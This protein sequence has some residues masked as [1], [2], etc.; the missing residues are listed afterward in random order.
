M[1][2]LSPDTEL[3]E[4]FIKASQKW[5]RRFMSSSLI[6]VQIRVTV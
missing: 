3:C 4:D 2:L 6:H 5:R 1:P